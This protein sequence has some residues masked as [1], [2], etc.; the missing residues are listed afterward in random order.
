MTCFFRYYISCKYY[1]NKYLTEKVMGV[2]LV[3]DKKD[4][5]DIKKIDRNMQYNQSGQSGQKWLSPM[6]H[7]FH[8]AGFAWIDTERVYR[9]LPQNPVYKITNEIDSL[10]NCTAG[11]QIRFQTNSSRLS[12]K[13]T[14]SG[15]ADMPHMPPTG[16]CGFDCYL[17]MPGESIKYCN[18]TKYNH[19]EAVYECLLFDLNEPGMQNVTLNF[20]LYQGVIEVLIGLDQHAE[21]LAPPEYRVDK[22]VIFYGTSITQGGCASRPGMAYTN[23]IS[24]RINVECINLGFSGNGRGEPD[25][26]RIISGIDR[27]AC[28]VLDYE[29]NCVSKELFH[30]TLP[31]FI[32]ILRSAHPDIPILVVSRISYA[33]DITDRDIL[34]TR[35]QLNEF[36]REI[37]HGLR[38]K[39]DNRIFFYDGTNLLGD[40]FDECTVDGV[41]PT[42]LGFMCM[43]DK[44]TPV[45]EKILFDCYE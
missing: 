29:A 7:P 8:I 39:G 5:F 28:F 45:L 26:A 17:G 30:R 20:P 14:L 3:A 11:G 4:N 15:V 31:E 24:R 13:V 21:V 43:A 18:T 37:V 38:A 6:Q 34:Q 16:Q 35:I 27:P 36:Q 10:A 9:R 1:H 2:I 19:K 41:H 33:A 22:R 40:N 23:I 42:D 12:I 25:M 44:L 32:H